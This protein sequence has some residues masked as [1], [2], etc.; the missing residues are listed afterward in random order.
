MKPHTN[1]LLTRCVLPL[2]CFS[3]E[4]D[5]LWR[6]D[7]QEYIR[8]VAKH[9]FLIATICLSACL[10]TQRCAKAMQL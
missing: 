10:A 8:K 6:E 4:D 7:P 1:E 3:E 2:M 5:E 9:Q